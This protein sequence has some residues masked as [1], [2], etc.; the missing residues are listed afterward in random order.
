LQATG[1]FTKKIVGMLRIK[2]PMVFL[3]L[4]EAWGVKGE[5][6][7]KMRSSPVHQHS[8]SFMYFLPVRLENIAC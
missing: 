7:G 8:S 6:W 2:R 3:G 5:R 1:K 4:G